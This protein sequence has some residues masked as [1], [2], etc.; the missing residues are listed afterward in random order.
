[1]LNH[2]GNI[3]GEATIANLPDGRVWY[4]SAAASEAHDMD[5]LTQ[6]IGAQEDVKIR[7]LTNDYTILVLAGPK[8]R[9]VLSKASRADWSAQAFPWLSV[10]QAFVGIAPAIVMS[11][12]F[13]GELAYEIHVPNNQLYAAYCALRAAGADHGLKLFGARAVDS[14]RMEKGYRHWKA[15]LVTEFNPFES[16][17]ARFVNLDKPTFIG[18]SALQHMI[19]APP[20]R[21]FVTLILDCNRAPAH[22]GDSVV[23]NGQVVGTVT[24]AD[25][26]HRISKNIAYAYVKPQF[27]TPGTELEVT[28]IGQP[29]SATVTAQSLYDP[30]TRLSKE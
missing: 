5:W 2:H 30:E 16:D 19:S 23:H 22:G 24:S 20:R 28:V 7:S 12:S 14:M 25:W 27:S 10:R 13:S 11:V 18:K 8:S 17:L 1:L 6:H 21:Q 9:T 26:G 29:V 3:K 15:D 4:G